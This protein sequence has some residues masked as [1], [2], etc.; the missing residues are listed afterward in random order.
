MPEANASP[1]RGSDH[2]TADGAETLSADALDLD[3]LRMRGDVDGLLVLA[4]AY[5]SGS[6]PGGRDMQRCLDAYRAAAELGSADAEYAV[7]LFSM[8]GGIGAQDLKE[9]TT[10]LRGA[11]ERG[12]VPAK[13]YLGNLYELGIHYKADPEKA[14][15]WY[16]NAARGALVEAEPGSEEHTR[17]LAALGCVRYLLALV[18]SG[19]V[20]GDDE[21]RL[22]Q[23]ARAHGYGLRMRD[24]SA[25]DRPTFLDSLEKADGRAVAS[26]STSTTESGDAAARRER[27]RRATTPDTKAA[28]AAATEAARP[29][30]EAPAKDSGPSRAAI[31]LGAFGYAL[32]F[33]VAGLGAAYASTLGARE[34]ALHGRPLPGLGER[35]D[36]VFPIVLGLVGVLPTWLV[37]RLGTVIKALV[38]AAFLGGIG[39]VAWGTG[40]AE[41]HGLRPVQALAFGLAGFLAALLVLGLTGGTKRQPRQGQR[42]RRQRS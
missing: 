19:A 1:A 16:R 34:L 10:R 23:R 24:E 27:Q 38:V 2:E 11:A 35:T 31:G 21:A 37:Y 8:S 22:L 33:A 42:P 9:G 29:R 6:V 15:V 28:R 25:T 36:A 13:V 4:R 30:N 20:S 7:A 41:L 17:A 3:A 12:S 5:R 40:Q 14:D 18:E 39:W 32:L 26:A